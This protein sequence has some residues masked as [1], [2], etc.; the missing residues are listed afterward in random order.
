ME[1]HGWIPQVHY[2][3]KEALKDKLRYTNIFQEFISAYT[4]SNQAA[5]R[6]KV[7]TSMLH[8]QEL[9]GEVF[10]EKT[11]KPSKGIIWL[12]IA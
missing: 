8:P 7:A 11:E 2:F 3:V 9:G 6:C 1:Q 12:A 4:N 5:H 10:I